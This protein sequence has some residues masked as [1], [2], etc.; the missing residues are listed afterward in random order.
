MR[1]NPRKERSTCEL[2]VSIIGHN[3]TKIG[4]CFKFDSLEYKSVS[5]LIPERYQRSFLYICCQALFVKSCDL[6]LNYFIAL[7]IYIALYILQVV[8]CFCQ[9]WFDRSIVFHTKLHKRLCVWTV[10]NEGKHITKYT[11]IQN[12]VVFGSKTTLWE[13]RKK[14]KLLVFNSNCCNSLLL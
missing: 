7:F 6:H 14:W 2:K 13:S 10:V 12:L 5:F 1:K 3:A 8:W 4:I 11:C 9:F